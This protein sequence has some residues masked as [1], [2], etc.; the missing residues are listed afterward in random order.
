M[1]GFR[2]GNTTDSVTFLEY[3]INSTNMILQKGYGTYHT[4]LPGETL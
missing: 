2:K 3:R 1:T 4:C